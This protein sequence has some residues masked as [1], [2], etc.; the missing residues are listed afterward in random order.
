MC[1]WFGSRPTFL[2]VC[3]A[4]QGR[5]SREKRKN[6]FCLTQQNGTTA[7][8]N[9]TFLLLLLRWEEERYTDGV[10]W[11]FLEH[12]GPVF[13]P[14]YERLPENVRFYYDGELG[15]GVIDPK[16]YSFPVTACPAA[17]PSVLFILHATSDQSESRTADILHVFSF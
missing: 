12:K 17:L 16:V 4:I 9:L 3:T 2:D 7:L 1:I 14:P 10:K 6:N 15:V 11:R 5:R 8:L 13:A